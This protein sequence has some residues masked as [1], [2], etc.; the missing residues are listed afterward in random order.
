MT[1]A[2]AEGRVI[3]TIQSLEETKMY[4]ELKSQFPVAINEEQLKKISK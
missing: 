2:E 1:F 3:K 4:N